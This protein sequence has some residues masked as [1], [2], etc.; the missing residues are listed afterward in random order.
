MKLRGF[1]VC[2]RVWYVR[3]WMSVESVK[4]LEYSVHGWQEIHCDFLENLVSWLVW[5]TG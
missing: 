2:W 5:A 1:S 3:Q 4:F